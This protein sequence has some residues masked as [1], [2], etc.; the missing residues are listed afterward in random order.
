MLIL[1]AKFRTKPETR[2]RMK[3][4]ARGLIGPSRAEEGCIVYEFLQDA[5]DPDAFT[6]YE[7]WR[8]MEDLELHFKEP[9]FLKFA[10]IF[11]GLIDGSESI[12][13]YEVSEEK[14]LA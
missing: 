10:E 6:F 1:I 9:H 11:P 12:I 3:E 14:N 7:R 4:M 8:S 5:F 2:D 13:A